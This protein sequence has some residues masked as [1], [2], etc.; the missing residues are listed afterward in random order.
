M[1]RE[2][3]VVAAFFF[4]FCLAGVVYFVIANTW[5]L[6]YKTQGAVITEIV[7]GNTFRLYFIE[8]P[9]KIKTIYYA[10]L[11]GVDA[12]GWKEDGHDCFF[13]EAKQFLGNLILGKQVTIKW[14]SGA[15]VD[16]KIGRI[17]VYAH[18]GSFQTDV[19]ARILLGGYG[20]VPRQYPADRKEQYLQLEKVARD[21]G[22][23]LWGSCSADYLQLL[24]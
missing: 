19:G 22:K 5:K 2:I 10:N 14:D 4:V 20:W 17:F 21:A 16:E 24:Q 7:D 18:T 23:G 3:V 1:K 13:E 8:D 12:P 9:K 11:M 6:E 15:K